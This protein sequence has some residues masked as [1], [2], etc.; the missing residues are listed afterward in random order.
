MLSVICTRNLKKKK[1]PYFLFVCVFVYVFYTRAN[2]MAHMWLLDDKFQES[3]GSRAPG[4]KLRSP[5]LSK[6]ILSS[7]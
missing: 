4:I 7:S 2:I 3:V 1:A 5:G 6:N